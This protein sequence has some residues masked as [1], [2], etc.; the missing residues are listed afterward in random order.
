MQTNFSLVQLADPDIRASEQILRACVHCGFCTATC[1]TYVLLGDELDS[2]RGRIYLLKQ[3]LEGGGPAH[4]RTVRHIDRCLSCLSCMTTCPSGVHYQHLVDH[5]RKHI[6]ET[7]RRPLADRLVRWL[8]ATTVPYPQRF[9]AT[10]GLAKLARPFVA[11]LPRSLFGGRLHAMLAMTPAT[12]PA[13]SNVDV[14]QTFPAV[15][16]RRGRVALL[17]GCAQT[18]LAPQINEATVRLLTRLGVEVVVASGAGCCGSLVH[19][20]GRVDQSHN[21][22]RAT[23]DAWIRE[24]DGAGLDA[25]IINTSG[26]GT[27]VK[28]YGFMFREDAAYAGKA[29]RVAGLARDVTEY[30]VELAGQGVTV[31]PSP[32]AA[33]LRVTYHS[34]CSMQHGQKIV[35]PPRDLLR[36]AGFAVAEPAEGHLCCGSAGTYNLLQRD[37]AD[38]LKA[39]KAE[40]IRATAPDVVA[41]GNIGCMTQLQDAVGVPIVH[42][43]E[44][45]DWASGGP[46]PAALG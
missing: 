36:G 3:M 20:I 1:P 23:I 35:R 2:P 12:I 42:T 11:L 18:V 21:Q 19:H 17:N 6:E 46:K 40:N 39:R 16:P 28:D 13:P 15:G 29:A 26:C 32:A 31:G 4:E 7:Y 34:A 24:A 44:L 5:G 8:L 43:V 45:L 30:L 41:A 25:I 9:R 27:Q 38:R 22:A 10:L 37:L 14:P 33:G